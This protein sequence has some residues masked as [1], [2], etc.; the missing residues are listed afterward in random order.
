MPAATLVIRNIGELVTCDPER[1]PTPGVI[2][3]AIVAAAGETLIY[4]GPAA[5]AAFA[6]AA[7]AAE[8]DAG[9]D[10][11]VPGFVDSHTHLVWLGD[12]ADEYAL[13]AAGASYEAIAAA[14]GGIRSTVSATAAGS[15]EDLT[16]SARE[17]ARRMLAGGTTT[18]E[19]KSGYGM[20]HAAELR[21]L[22]AARRLRHD[23]E[24]P[25]VVTTYLPLHATPDTDRAAFL[26]GVI[27]EGLPQAAQRARFVDAFCE[28]GAWTPDECATLFEAA[29]PHGLTAR[30][31][32]EQRTRS[33]GAMLAAS[34]H[35]ASADHLEHASD[36]DLRALA[37]AGVVGVML[38][39]AA[40][41][42]DGPPPPG[43]RMIDAGG[44]VA[45]ATD[46]N[47]GT[48]WSESMALMT[49]LAVATAGMTPA[50]ALIAA[51]HGGARALRL[52]D[53]GILRA[54]L[55]CDLVLLRSRRWLDVAYHLGGDVV[56]TVIRGGSVV[57]R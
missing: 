28:N 39:G 47:P 46:C 21:Q 56:A 23:P 12:R 53:R 30:L 36:A 51:T 27:R 57:V 20:S 19:V 44:V 10:A 18:V 7:D 54:G 41:I 9:G 26:D 13:R 22:D 33:G 5:G 49:S 34:V 6:V 38:P 16:E 29:A 3:D 11:A 24:C 52:N 14:G 42:L 8:W 40:L 55:R 50:E 2:H 17:R 48:C 43:R 15:V 25:D 4:V 45:I 32:A 1:E 35:A 31:H 37:G